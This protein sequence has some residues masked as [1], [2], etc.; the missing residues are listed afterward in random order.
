M[1]FKYIVVQGDCLS[2]IAARN[3]FNDWRTIYNDPQNESFRQE[4]PDPNLIYPGDEIFIPDK[5]IQSLPSATDQRHR[6]ELHN[7]STSLRV[8]LKDG[9]DRPY[10]NMK[11]ILTVDNVDFPGNTNAEG[12][13]EQAINPL[14]KT[15]ELSVF[16]NGD[17]GPPAVWTLALGHLDPLKTLKGIQARLNN[18]GFDAGPVDGIDGPLTRAGV[19]AF[20]AKH[21]L[22]VDGIAGP[23]TQ[24]KL[25]EV[26]GC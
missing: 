1:A 5:T 14:A 25:K 17:D 7:P 8:F 19:K 4:R 12:L 22:T 24:S 11:F 3:G 16:A 21:G 6:F 18:L 23:K 26:Y 20:Q 10:A 13:V 2:S 9:D 15:A